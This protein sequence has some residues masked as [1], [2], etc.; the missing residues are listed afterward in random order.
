MILYEKGENVSLSRKISVKHVET[1]NSLSRY[2]LQPRR[3]TI[4]YKWWS[5]FLLVSIKALFVDIF[6]AQSIQFS[7][8]NDFLSLPPKIIRFYKILMK[9]TNSIISLWSQEFF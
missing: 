3:I 8:E 1:R 5:L 9:N 4:I 7:F 6:S 2:K